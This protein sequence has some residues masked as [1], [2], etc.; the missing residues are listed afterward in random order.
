[1]IW[2]PCRIVCE[3]TG[4]TWTAH[5]LPPPAP[6]VAVPS[7]PSAGAALVGFAAADAASGRGKS[8]TN[9]TEMAGK[10]DVI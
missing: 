10:A 3:T 1:M 2:G 5:P 8:R 6:F 7:T 9:R 4:Q